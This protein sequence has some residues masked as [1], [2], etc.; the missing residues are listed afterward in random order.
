MSPFSVGRSTHRSASE[1]SGPHMLGSS[2]SRGVYEEIRVKKN[3]AKILKSTNIISYIQ[4][5]Q[6]SLERSYPSSHV[7]ELHPDPRKNL[8]KTFYL[9]DRKDESPEG[10]DEE[11]EE[12]EGIRIVRERTEMT[13]QPGRSAEPP[14][15]FGAAMPEEIGSS[16]PDEQSPIDVPDDED[17]SEIVSVLRQIP[18]FAKYTKCKCFGRWKDNA[19]YEIEII[20]A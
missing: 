3:L 8:A 14:A 5:R 17:T 12:N 16:S 15:R 4:S 9:H 7:H 18:F 13:P 10:G 19:V 6:Q 20:T 11:A 1:S 2:T